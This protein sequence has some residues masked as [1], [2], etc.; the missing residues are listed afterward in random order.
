MRIACLFFLLFVFSNLSAQNTD[1]R[2]MVVKDSSGQLYPFD[3]WQALFMKGNYILK[4]EHP[5]EKN[6]AYFL[7]R[8]SEEERKVRLEKMPKPRPSNF[9]KNGKKVQ[10]FKSEDLAGNK[11]DLTEAKGKIIVLNFWFIN[12]KP[13]RM[14]IP[15]LNTLVDSFRNNEKVLFVGIALDDKDA[16]NKFINTNPFRY[17]L[18]PAGN[19]IAGLYSVKSFPTHAVIDQ[20]GKVYFHTTGLALNTVYWVEKSIRELLAKEDVAKQ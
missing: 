3:I 19:Y 7:V 14:E 20:E 10:L 16:I 11:L 2:N 18:V 1:P 17:T 9:F 6:T 15:D 8:I 5:K 12:C 4:P 13:C